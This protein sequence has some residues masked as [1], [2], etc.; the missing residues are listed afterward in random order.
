MTAPRAAASAK[1]DR[2]P[3]GVSPVAGSVAVV[4]GGGRGIGR[5][6]A[7]GL[8]EAGA[9]V[10][11]VARSTRE[12]SETAEMVE[13]AGGVAAAAAAD[14][15]DPPA[16]AAAFDALRD[17]IGPVD[18][19]VNNAGVGGPVGRAWEVDGDDWWRTCEINLRGVFVCAQL[20]LGQMVARGR[21]RIINVTS[22]AAVH[23]WP[24]VSAYAVSKAAVVKLTENLAAELRDHGISVFSVHPGLVPIGLTEAALSQG[25]PTP[26]EERVASWLRQELA[27]GRG[28]DPAAA[29]ALVTRLASG[30]ADGLSGRHL[31]VHDD[32]DSLL[33]SAEEI[34][35]HDLCTL[36]LREPVG[37]ARRPA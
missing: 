5:V 29:A 10:G 18:V 2:A 27:E 34:R 14:V 1:G 23:R 11:V 3:Q 28:A 21:G 30:E 17:E 31:S 9:A 12:L 8:A 7:C 37:A 25:A 22:A 36:R 26:A 20:A 33:A 32:L 13:A 24:T 4:T 16:A 35:A 6:L 19:L 15:S